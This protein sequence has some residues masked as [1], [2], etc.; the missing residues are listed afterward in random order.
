MAV[1]YSGPHLPYLLNIHDI[2]LY[3]SPIVMNNKEKQCNKKSIN[4]FQI[5]KC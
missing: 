2:A 3:T 5:V 4:A 1:T